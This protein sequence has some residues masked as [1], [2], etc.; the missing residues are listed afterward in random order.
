MRAK[1]HAPSA[2]RPLKPAQPVNTCAPQARVAANKADDLTG[3][4]INLDG[5]GFGVDLHGAHARG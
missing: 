5:T 3:D 2:S 1:G 4:L